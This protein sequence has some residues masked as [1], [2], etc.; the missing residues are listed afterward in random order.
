MV[1][2]PVTCAC[3]VRLA[4]GYML[5][6]R[7][8]RCGMMGENGGVD[9]LVSEMVLDIRKEWEVIFFFFFL[10]KMVLIV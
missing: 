8:F 2:D 6:R 9:S 1:D 3:V 7:S 10:I 4:P 5:A